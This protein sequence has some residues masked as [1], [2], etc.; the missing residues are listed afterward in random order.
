MLSR[1]GEVELELTKLNVIGPFS[2]L[3]S[4]LK[5]FKPKKG[6]LFA[7]ASGDPFPGSLRTHPPGLGDGSPSFA[8]P[9]F[10]QDEISV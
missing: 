8:G 7:L 9:Q 5:L 3:R 1:L 2:Q 6:M 4:L 10:A